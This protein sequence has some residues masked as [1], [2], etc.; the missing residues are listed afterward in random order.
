MLSGRPSGEVFQQP[1]K[2]PEV[3]RSRNTNSE[4]DACNDGDFVVCRYCNISSL[5]NI[6]IPIVAAVRSTFWANPLSMGSGATIAEAKENALAEAIEFEALEHVPVIAKRASYSVLSLDPNTVD[7]ATIPGCRKD[8]YSPSRTIDWVTCHELFSNSACNIPH[9]A[10]GFSAD[11]IFD[12]STNGMGV[13]DSRSNALTHALHETIERHVISTEVFDSQGQLRTSALELFE[14]KHQLPFH[15]TEWIIRRKG[16][17]FPFWIKND[18]GLHVFMT[19]LVSGQEPGLGARN[20]MTIGYGCSDDIRL[21]FQK[22]FKEALQV[23]IAYVNGARP[24]LNS[25]HFSGK[26]SGIH[27]WL[28]ALR[29]TGAFSSSKSLVRTV[30]WQVRFNDAMTAVSRLGAKSIL[31]YDFPKVNARHVVKVLV[32]DLHFD[33][34]LF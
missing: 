23:H 18:S 6:P 8:Q 2:T 21:A 22:S 11:L 1:A 17:V 19:F 16:G 13:S 4:F 3:V 14:P 20:S 15:L 10:I 31:S 32:P 28:R 12:F 33:H 24:G 5:D 34:R 9:S 25:R 30:D 26:D 7:P 29:P 27:E